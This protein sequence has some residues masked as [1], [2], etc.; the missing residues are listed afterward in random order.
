MLLLIFGLLFKF[1]LHS[2]QI[3]L[4]GFGNRDKTAS[5]LEAPKQE[6]IA[7]LPD[8]KTHLISAAFGLANGARGLSSTIAP[9]TT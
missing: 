7:C 1:D 3:S 2:A 5:A 9:L 8:R 6:F 4:S